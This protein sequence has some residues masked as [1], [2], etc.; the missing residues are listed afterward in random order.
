[1][2]EKP[3]EDKLFVQKDNEIVETEKPQP[4]IKEEAK[5]VEK[6]EENKEEKSAL[7][8]DSK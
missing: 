4:A 1:M 2:V 6:K 8:K 3:V 5:V 7:K